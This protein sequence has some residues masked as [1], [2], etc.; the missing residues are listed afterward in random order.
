MNKLVYAS[1]LDQTL[2]FSRKYLSKYPCDD[3]LVCV[4][5]S[6]QK[7]LS[8][9]SRKV[10]IALQELLQNTKVQ[11]IPV[12]T[13]D[14]M[15]YRRLNLGTAIYPQY[16]IVANGG[17]ILRNN[18]PIPEWSRLIKEY[19]N[20]S[21]F[22][23]VIHCCCEKFVTRSTP[24]SIIDSIMIMF[25]VTDISEFDERVFDLKCQFP[26]WQF[27]RQGSKCYA[28][29][30]RITKGAALQWLSEQIGAEFVV[31]TGDGAM[32]LSMLRIANIALVPDTSELDESF[33]MP[34]KHGALSALE[35]IHVVSSK[36]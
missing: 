36:L 16:A 1:D 23:S 33:C 17:V 13:R 6:D 21:E 11:F 14:I 7:E 22:S 5:R 10:Q 3:D 15:R 29:P 20:N 32:D 8:Y 25:K 12:T 2:I 28:I 19:L 26:N 9:I 4:E 34:V 35:T 18:R 24:V 30:K 31:A 27:T